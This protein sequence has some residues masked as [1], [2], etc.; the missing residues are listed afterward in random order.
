MAIYRGAG[1][2][3][4][5]TADS[6]NTA[7]LAQT[8]A[9]NAAASA[10]A[11]ASS[12]SSASS[13]STSAS[14]SSSSA[15]ASATAAANSATAAATSA[16]NAASSASAAASSASTASTAAA[17]AADS[18]TAA[19]TAQTAAETA[20]T[21]AETA[22]AAAEAA[23]S[24]AETAET[25]AETAQTAAEAAQAAAEAARDATLSA[26]D[27]FDDRYLGVKSSDPTLDNDG[28]AL[29][30]G[31]LY[32]NS[33]SEVMRLYTGSAWTDAYTTGS[34]FLQITQNLGDLD[35]VA[36]ARTNLGL[37]TA[38][39]EN[40]GYFATAA[41]GV[42][43]DTAYGWGNHASAGYLTSYTETDPVF[44]AHPSY[45]ITGTKIS[46]WDDSYS[47]V[48]AFPTQTSNSGKFLT[49]DGSS[50]SF[51]TVDA[52]PAGTAVALAIALG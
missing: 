31:S 50:L 9:N 34:S 14:T 22:Q 48:A 49:T 37:G 5:A 7:Q 38:A 20:Q 16:S 47:F 52:D 45:G 44:V 51:A 8:Y 2:P 33:T 13:S 42:N 26:Y 1:G 15:A 35:N 17:T 4:D 39:V 29:V 40:V 3:G 18:K 28:N 32:F 25:G 23:Q 11:A 19:E 30:A 43:A 12:A 21:A 46:N 10:A 41:Q 6:A 24:G 27:N 36:T